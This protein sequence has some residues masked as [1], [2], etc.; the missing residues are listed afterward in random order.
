MNRKVV[1]TYF[2]LSI[3]VIVSAVALAKQIQHYLYHREDPLAEVPVIREDPGAGEEDYRRD[4]QQEMQNTMLVFRQTESF[5]PLATPIPRPTPTPP[6]LPT[7]TPVVPA[8][9]YK[10]VMATRNMVI[11][12]NYKNEDITVKVGNT[13]PDPLFGDFR[14]VE[15]KPNPSFLSPVVVVEDVKSGARRDLTEMAPRK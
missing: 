2:F 13:V 10:I 12:R 15:V 6:P 11:L 7:A 9:N 4:L 3:F 8:R 1:L 5:K 14:V